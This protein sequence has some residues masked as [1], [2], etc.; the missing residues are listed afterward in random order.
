MIIHA[1]F[2]RKFFTDKKVFIL[3]PFPCMMTNIKH[4]DSRLFYSIVSLWYTILTT[5]SFFGYITLFTWKST[6]SFS[7]FDIITFSN[8]F[9]FWYPQLLIF[10]CASTIILNVCIIV[11][12]FLRSY[13]LLVYREARKIVNLI[14]KLK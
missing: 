11:D 10:L 4:T 9:H 6:G 13:M 8:Y 2:Q 5:F 7:E 3:R 1:N 12:W 14:N